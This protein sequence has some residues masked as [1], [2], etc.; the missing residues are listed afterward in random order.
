[1][2]R[3]LRHSLVFAT[4]SVIVFSLIHGNDLY[5]SDTHSAFKLYNPANLQQITIGRN[6]ESNAV[7]DFSTSKAP[8]YGMS[9]NMKVVPLKKNFIVRVLL[10]DGTGHHHLVA[11]SY[12]E[13]TPSTDLLSFEDYSEET[14]LLDGVVP[15]KLK[16][17]V[18]NAKVQL[19]S[20][21]VETG[22]VEGKSSTD[23]RKEAIKEIRLLQQQEK[24]NR[25]NRYNYDEG[26][27]WLAGVTPLCMDD[28]ETR[29]RK[30]GAS[31]SC[32]TDGFEYYT[33][34]IFFK[35]A[36]TDADISDTRG[37]TSLLPD[38]SGDS[39]VNR[40]SWNNRHGKDWMT[41]VKDQGDSGY[42]SAFTAVSCTEA[43]L[44]LYLNQKVDLDLSEQQA[45]CCNGT[46]RP[47]KGMTQGAPL[48]YIRDHGIYEETAYPFSNDT[49]EGAICR[50][51]A[52]TYHQKVSISNYSYVLPKTEENIK[53]AL[54]KQ[55][56][57]TS[58][59]L[60]GNDSGGHAMSLVGYFKIER[61]DSLKVL[62]HYS[63]GCDD[64]YGLDTMIV[65]TDTMYKHLRL[66]GQTCWIYKN[67]HSAE[68]YMHLFYE[69]LS[70]C[71]I[72]PYKIDCP[73]VWTS[74]DENGI[75]TIH[76]DVVCEDADGDGFYFWGLGPKPANCPPSVPDEPDGDDSNPELGPMDDY[77]HLQ[78][79]RANEL[80]TIYIDTTQ[81]TILD[82][83]YVRH[84]VVRNNAVWNVK[85]SLSFYGGASIT[86]KSG[87]TLNISDAAILENTILKVEPGS[88]INITGNAR[89]NTLD[90]TDFKVPLGATV[91]I[92]NGTIN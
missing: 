26:Y 84:I 19:Q 48:K 32:S 29:M 62:R 24:A 70:R 27:L 59:L 41:P 9:V 82:R 88:I 5:A 38:R 63:G 25:I 86:V 65:V 22:I 49:T 37:S 18:S 21:K 90:G 56:P 52:V 2:I 91:N 69:N 35:S 71:M 68:P 16:V 83:N 42:C 43:L 73:I 47:W 64:C 75:G 50:D 46:V 31:H 74:Y 1:M 53:K 85:H 8:I 61:G 45:A 33:E 10:E 87:C 79:L 17:Y 58:G 40:F 57:L 51:A 13:I 23:E 11:E 4:V 81:T 6:L 28:Y 44:N 12:R 55:G 80:D 66:I 60:W 76:N 7:L 54:I 72:T 77:G 34:G 30:L 92:A 39:C 78:V 36:P 14:S 67:S 15:R 3:F 89:V 20:V